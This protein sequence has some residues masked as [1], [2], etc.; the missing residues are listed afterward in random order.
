M[1]TLLKFEASWCK[2]C[3]ALAPIVKQLD[4]EDETLIVTAVDID[5]NPQLR[6][7][8]HIRSVP[9]LV[10]ISEG[11]EIARRTG[12]GLL[13]ELKAWVDESRDI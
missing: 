8:Y 12:G 11:K 13:S 10:L 4:E 9:T 3:Q 6:A 2:P 1:L 7:D 5:D